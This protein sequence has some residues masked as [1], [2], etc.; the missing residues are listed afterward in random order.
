[1]DKEIYVD[2]RH[3]EEAFDLNFWRDNGKLW[4]MEIP[5]EAMDINE[6][7]WILNVPFWEDAE[8]NI[9][10][11]PN[12]VL[13]SP[14]A[15]PEHY[16]RIINADVSFPIHI[17]PNKNGKWLTLDG[18]HRLAK[19]ELNG[20]TSVQVKKVTREQVEQTKRDV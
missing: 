6:L 10:I 1:M 2:P 15:Y 18:L 8:G 11:A 16:D 14:A 7:R 13:N 4:E 5:T 3:S 17:M 19:L 12:D 9:T 20:A